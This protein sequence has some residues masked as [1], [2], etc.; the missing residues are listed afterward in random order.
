MFLIVSQTSKKKNTDC[1]CGMIQTSGA[2]FDV[3]S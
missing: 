3:I 1:F 2:F